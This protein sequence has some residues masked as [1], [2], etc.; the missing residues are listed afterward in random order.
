MKFFVS[1]S[2]Q[3][4]EE[5]REIYNKIKIRGHTITHDWTLT[6]E[7]GSYRDNI[8]EAHARADADIQGVINADVYILDSNN[9][10]VGKFMYG[11]LASAITAQKLQGLPKNIYIIGPLNHESILYYHNSIKHLERIEDV[12]EDLN[13]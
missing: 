6:D 8:K 5:I 12:F 3:H 2:I 4:K 1:G 7:I 9:E 11:E 10:K 13:I